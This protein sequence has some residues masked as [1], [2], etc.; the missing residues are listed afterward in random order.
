M[1]QT[2]PLKPPRTQTLVVEVEAYEADTNQAGCYPGTIRGTI[3]GGRHDQQSV[4]I[5]ITE[6]PTNM[7]TAKVSDLT[8][9]KAYMYTPPGGYITL[10]GAH[11]SGDR[12]HASWASR[13]A[14]PEDEM[15]IGL[16]LQIAAARDAE[17]NPRLYKSNSAT[18]Y[19]VSILHTPRTRTVD[20]HGDLFKAVSDCFA[21]NRAALIMHTDRTGQRPQRSSRYFWRQWQNGAPMPLDEAVLTIF[22]EPM[23]TELE[24][25]LQTCGSIDVIPVEPLRVGPFTAESIDKGQRHHVAL[26]AYRT[27]GL[28]R[29]VATALRQVEAVEADAITQAFLAGLNPDKKE[30]FGK[31]GWPAMWNTDIMR[32]FR[33]LGQD[34]PKVPQMGYAESVAVLKPFNTLRNG[35]Q[36]HF[37]ARSRALGAALPRDALPTRSDPDAAK[38]YYS[39]FRERVQ[40]AARVLLHGHDPDSGPS[41]K[42]TLQPTDPVYDGSST[43]PQYATDPIDS[44]F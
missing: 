27:G 5:S 37:L 6:T 15:R 14:G 13:L 43:N 12:V 33:G 18:V 40:G 34:L 25:T 42:M 22:A 31:D 23:H 3:R 17:G 41:K 28:G 20:A 11:F 35:Q 36:E 19:N 32:F 44:N 9:D 39:D 8:S 16:P 10:S 21:D 2:R 29:R 30:G 38:R 24:V 7:K 4:A 1:T 26:Q